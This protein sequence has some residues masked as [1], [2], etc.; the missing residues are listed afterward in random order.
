MKVLIIAGPY[1]ADRIRR[2]VVSARFEAVAVEPGESLSGWIT[3]SRPD[4]IVLAPQ[5]VNPD[6][7][8]ALAKVRAVPRGRVPTF[9]VGDAEDEARMK[10]LADGF[11]TRPLSTADLVACV[12]ARLG[13]VPVGQ[14]RRATDEMRISAPLTDGGIPEFGR[15]SASKGGKSRPA[16]DPSH[17][18]NTGSFGP[19]AVGAAT[20]SR[21]PASGTGPRVLPTLKPLVAAADATAAPVPRAR[22]SEAGALFVKLAESIDAALD[23]EMLDVARSIGAFR[24]E[25]TAA[26]HPPRTGAG[27][28]P[29]DL[30]ERTPMAPMTALAAAAA[31]GN[32][33]EPTALT[34]PSPFDAED[35]LGDDKPQKT[36]EVPRDVFA[37]MIAERIAAA[38]DG[39]A[40]GGTPAPV[41][42][43]KI[44]DSDVASL[45]GRIYLQ[46]LTGRLVLR[47]DA[48]EKVI[49]SERGA[50]ILGMSSDSDDRLG[51]M[52]VRQGRLTPAQLDQASAAAP[53]AERRLGV[54]LVELGFIKPT[55]LSVV[56]RRH[57]EE[58]IHSAFAWESGEWSLGPGQP[59]QE[60]VLLD[61]HPAALILAGV[62]RKYSAARLSRC[63]GGGQQIFRRSTAASAI[64]VLALMAMTSEER[65]IVDLFDGTRTLDDV[66]AAAGVREE[67]A[68]GLAWT[69]SV[70]G[71]LDRVDNRMAEPPRATNG[72]GVHE[73]D[74][75][76]AATERAEMRA[77]ILARHALVEEGD[78]FELLDLSR[79][80]ADGE[81]AAA[82]DRLMREL[83]PTSLDAGLVAELGAELRAIRAV[84]DEALRVLGET[85][86][87]ARYEGHL[88]A[89]AEP[90]AARG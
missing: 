36:V 28:A 77:R 66:R 82:H 65:A 32:T 3:A 84:L 79:G 29:E 27:R 10:D 43:G 25:V 26:P 61:E 11:F 41:E 74:G 9:L 12:R 86:M 23:A 18:G 71:Q 56:V 5:I 48:V 4:V 58:I 35:E 45:L 30:F 88:P 75:A 73:V 53:R 76:R 81:I 2:A 72:T 51:E 7:A 87:R 6:P 40:E 39:G 19:A 42:S 64:D 62:R 85:S 67:V 22:P 60:I 78:Y 17:T 38:R 16:G 52:L 31:L 46:R 54:V 47:R 20:G 8:L 57:F 34:H 21:T 90:A 70:L 13:D 63:L 24:H 55:E 49:F 15:T 33:A 59:N 83:A 68:S 69:L 14:A 50:P 80:A 44:A 37:K 1:E 89:A